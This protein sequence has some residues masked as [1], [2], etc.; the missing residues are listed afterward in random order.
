MKRNI[1]FFKP[2]EVTTPLY[3]PWYVNLGSGL[4][5]LQKAISDSIELNYLDFYRDYK[6]PSEVN[7]IILKNVCS[8]LHSTFID[9]Y[10]KVN[11]NK[12]LSKDLMVLDNIFDKFNK[13]KHK[14]E[15]NIFNNANAIFHDK[16]LKRIIERLKE[17]CEELQTN[18]I[19]LHGNIFMDFGVF[20]YI[21]ADNL[22]LDI[23]PLILDN[24]FRAFHDKIDEEDSS[25]WLNDIDIILDINLSQGA[26]P[27]QLNIR[28]S[29]F[30]KY[31]K[32]F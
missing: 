14:L 24:V 11:R 15:D 23:P 3:H 16:V 12:L 10:K 8:F 29:V 25:Y 30:V 28:E 4:N 9:E 32:K 26:N 6:L 22:V 5:L 2:K 13:N 20:D 17:Y 31:R 18:I 27:Y 21:G 1:T 7:D 19:A